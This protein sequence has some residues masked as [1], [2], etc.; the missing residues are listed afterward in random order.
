[1]IGRIVIA[2]VVMAGLFLGLPW[3][4]ERRWPALVLALLLILIFTIHR[5]INHRK[6]LIHNGQENR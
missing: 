1:M 4:V 2:F 6:A 5:I 3:A